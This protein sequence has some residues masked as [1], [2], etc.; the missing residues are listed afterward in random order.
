MEDNNNVSAVE[1][2]VKI[3]DAVSKS[4]KPIGVSALSKE[5]GLPKATVFRFCNTL[6]NLGY[7]KKNQSD[8]FSLGLAFIT[9]GER[10]KADTNIAEL[11]KPY[12]EELAEETGEAVNLGIRQDTSVFT[13]LNV[14]GQESVLISKLVPICPIHCSAMGKVFLVNA[15]EEE[16]RKL[17]SSDLNKRTVNTRTTYEEYL[18]DKDFYDK[19]GVTMENEEY[20]YGLSCFGAPLYGYNG[21]LIAA[22]SLSAPRSRMEIKGRET[23]IKELI[24]TANKISKLYSRLYISKY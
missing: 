11:A 6:A 12:M 5:T 22:I 23:L 20:E 24:S 16:V 9:L 18:K 1:R 10:V 7:L 17:F 15:K 21:R 3:I 19:N 14:E 4:Q 13:L 2:V 8:E